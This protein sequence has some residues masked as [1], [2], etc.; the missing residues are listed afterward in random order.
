MNFPALKLLVIAAL[1]ALAN[2]RCELDRDLPS[3]QVE[4]SF[5]NVKN[6]VLLVR[7][8]DSLSEGQ[9]IYLQDA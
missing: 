5:P 6:A 3:V 1:V 2:A 8:G 4:E 7:N 9:T